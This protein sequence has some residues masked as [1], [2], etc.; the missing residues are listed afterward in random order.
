MEIIVFIATIVGLVAGLIAV[1]DK[2]KEFIFKK[3]RIKHIFENEFND[4]K[5]S[6]RSYVS[7]RE[8]FLTILNYIKNNKFDGN[9]ESFSIALCTHYGDPLLHQLIRRNLRN[10]KAYNVLLNMLEKKGV[11]VGW[12]AEYALSTMDENLLDQCASLPSE[13]LNRDNIQESIS[14]IKNKNVFQYLEN[15]AKGNDQKL[16]NYAKEVLKQIRE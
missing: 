5:D 14:R 15:T 2:S 4:W 8:T 9:R 11:R 13:Y 16:R 10:E 7:P 3:D 1:S 12:R 6:G